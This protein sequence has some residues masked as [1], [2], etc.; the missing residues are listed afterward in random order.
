MDVSMEGKHYWKSLINMAVIKF[1]ILRTLSKEPC[2]GYEILNRVSAFTQ[3]CC[4]P[5][6]GTIYPILKE[7]TK[8]GY[9]QVEEQT[10][11]NRKRKVYQLTDKGLLAFD[12]ASSC[13]E[14]ILPYLNYTVKG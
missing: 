4:A 1:L 10:V 13:W 3:G 9:A 2:H 7:L 5:T 6:Y 8:R 11:N 14:D 12:A